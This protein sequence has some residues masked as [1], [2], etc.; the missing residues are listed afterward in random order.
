[1]S[2]TPPK[3]RKL[4]H[5]FSQK[6]SYVPD[7]DDEASD[8]VYTS[9]EDAPVSKTKPAHTHS[10]KR[11]TIETGEGSL[12]AGGLFKSSM[13][14]FQVDYLLE[15]SKPNYE[16]LSVKVNETLGKL[17]DSI[18]SITPREPLPVSIYQSQYDPEHS[19]LIYQ[20][21]RKLLKVFKRYTKL[22]F[23]SPCPHQIRMLHTNFRTPGL[24]PSIL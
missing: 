3:R 15:E 10:K 23:R 24:R 19:M 9:D 14:K 18:E 2:P 17:K 1:M 13:F 8:N 12:Y 20:R 4:D 11:H 7:G 21:F 22:P 16:K 5:K 6:A